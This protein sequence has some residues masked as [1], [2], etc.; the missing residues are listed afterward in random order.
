V[1]PLGI[2][3]FLTGRGLAV[4]ESELLWVWL[5][6]TAIGLALWRRAR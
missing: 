1:S 5:P 3:A 2:S 4:I 6:S